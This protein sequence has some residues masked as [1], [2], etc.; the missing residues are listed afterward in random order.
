M[1]K[2]IKSHAL[3]FNRADI[4]QL[5]THLHIFVITSSVHRW[6]TNLLKL[7]SKVDNSFIGDDESFILDS[8]AS[9]IS[10]IY[11]TLVPW[12]QFLQGSFVWESINHVIHTW[13][14]SLGRIRKRKKITRMSF[15]QGWMPRILDEGRCS[16]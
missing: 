3:L 9:I 1:Y 16:T 12:M 7:C 13:K 2:L 5:R 14:I 11:C 8:Y 6:F 4:F 10:Q 15:G